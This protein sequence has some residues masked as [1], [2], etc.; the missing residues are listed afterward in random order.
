MNNQAK[1]LNIRTFTGV[2]ILAAIIVVLQCFC[3]VIKI[4]P[5]SI[6]LTLAP[7]LVGAAVYGVG[8][9]ALLGAVFGIIVFVTDSTALYLMGINFFMTALLCIG[10][11]I[12]AGVAAGIVYKLLS[13]KSQLA[14]I[15]LAGIVSPIVNTGAFVAGMLVFFKDIIYGWASSSG[16]PSMVAYIIF[17]LCGLN[18]IVE[19]VVNLVLSSAVNTIVSASAKFNNTVKEKYN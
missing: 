8:A 13:K 3:S 1:K 10:K 9:G 16:Q 14:A 18:F 19:L 2:A 17:G 5:V 15:V 11:G 4:G 12:L 6:T 7:I